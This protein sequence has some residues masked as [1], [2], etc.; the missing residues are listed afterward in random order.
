[1]PLRAVA[2]LV[3]LVGLAGA[4]CR[5]P[6]PDGDGR[7]RVAA[8][9][10][11]LADLA[12]RVGGDRVSVTDLTPPG[13]E[14]HDVELSS[15]D[16]DAV[17]DADVLLYLGGGFQP[18]VEKAARRAGRAVDLL[19]PGDGGDPHI[20]LDPDRYAAAATGVERALA[21]ADPPGAAG[22]RERAAALRR[23]LA[24]L[25]RELR[26]GL[27]ACARRLIVTSHDAFGHLAGRYGLE[28]E[29]I[30]G[31]SP[32]A[33][34]DPARLARLVDLVRRRG[35]TTVFTDGLASPRLAEALAREAG[36]AVAVL[37]PL[38]GPLEGGYAAAM[39]ANLASLRRALDCT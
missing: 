23:E 17:D 16:V 10:S 35:V 18:G 29:A 38:E 7:L 15:R 34:P 39:R 36:V 11:R 2:A 14:P 20:W 21:A 13:V 37:D 3:V 9:F 4:G 33:E 31:P 32:E 6:G 24:D 28:A 5:A 8:G 12:E 19:E 22:Y 26:A 1:M 30:A 25:D 27:E